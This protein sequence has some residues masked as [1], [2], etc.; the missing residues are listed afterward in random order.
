MFDIVN[1]LIFVPGILIALTVHEFA[2]GLVAYRLGD[3]TAK[4]AGRLTLNPIPHIDP[5]GFIFLFLVHI[6][7][8]KPV[9]VNPY[10]FKSPERD[11]AKVAFAGPLSN[12][13]LAF[14]ISLILRAFLL[15]PFSE[16]LVLF[17]LYKLL[18]ATYIINL[19][20]AFFNLIPIPPLDGS[21]I[22]TLF[23]PYEWKL[24]YRE[25]E[26][27]GFYLLAGLIFIS[28][29]LRIPIF[30]ILIFLPARLL[31]SIFLGASP[32]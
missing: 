11:M 22:V 31:S 32:F 25:I 19:I 3:P 15:F 6:G 17:Y 14:I 30:E 5:L 23:L 4:M 12:I 9:P 13:L 8:A 21:K 2:H 24:R 1:L 26:P 10:Y 28:Y 7:W 18:L 16:N 29:F 20:L 27:Y